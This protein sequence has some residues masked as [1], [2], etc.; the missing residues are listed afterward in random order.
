MHSAGMVCKNIM[1]NACLFKDHIVII[2]TFND[3]DDNNNIFS[4]LYRDEHSC[5]M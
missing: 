5:K 3:S 4:E 1:S 2:S